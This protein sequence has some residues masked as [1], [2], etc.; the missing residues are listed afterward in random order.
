M[1][2]QKIGLALLGVGFLNVIIFSSLASVSLLD[3][4]RIHSISRECSRTIRI[5]GYPGTWHQQSMLMNISGN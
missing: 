1:N 3:T 4:L 5:S 2:R